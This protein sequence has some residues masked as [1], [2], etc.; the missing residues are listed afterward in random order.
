MNISDKTGDKLLILCFLSETD[1]DRP[2][3]HNLFKHCLWKSPI[4][5]QTFITVL[6]YVSSIK[7]K[8]N[9]LL[10]KMYKLKYE[11]FLFQFPFKH[12]KHVTNF[13]FLVLR[14]SFPHDMTTCHRQ[15]IMASCPC[16]IALSHMRQ[17]DRTLYPVLGWQNDV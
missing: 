10:Y 7:L 9:N 12:L 16:K 15:Y 3:F 13:K 14:R 5:L 11:V 17:G 8:M 1:S 6:Q 2:V 4:K